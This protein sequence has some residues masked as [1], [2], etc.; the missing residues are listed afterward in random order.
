MIVA[1]RLA[2]ERAA[3]VPDANVTLGDTFVRTAHPD[4]HGLD[5]RGR[6]DGV[7]CDF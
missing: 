3:R 5:Y 1:V 2:L 7:Y 6:Y 4:D